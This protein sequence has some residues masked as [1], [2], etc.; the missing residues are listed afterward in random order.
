M[1]IRSKLILV[2]RVAPAILALPLT[3]LHCNGDWVPVQDWWVLV[4]HAS[5]VV[6]TASTVPLLILLW[7]NRIQ[8]V[9]TTLL[10]VLGIW[11]LPLS[12]AAP[13]GL[14]IDLFDVAYGRTVLLTGMLFINMV[15]IRM[16]AECSEE[17]NRV[18]LG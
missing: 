4:L 13:L 18:V 10:G 1:T 11:A 3:N 5:L 14:F 6:G 8:H 17:S 2:I 9:A 12:A 7:A 16:L 15:W